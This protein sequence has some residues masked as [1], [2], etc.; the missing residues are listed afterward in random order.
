M[1]LDALSA[2]NLLEFCHELVSPSILL[3]VY[4]LSIYAHEFFSVEFFSGHSV[5][6]LSMIGSSVIM[7]LNGKLG[8]DRFIEATNL[9]RQAPFN[10]GFYMA[11]L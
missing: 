11:K 4:V 2:G 1:I 8:Y 9:E 5:F 3:I 10:V 7:T 6:L